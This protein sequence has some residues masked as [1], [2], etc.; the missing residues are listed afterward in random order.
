MKNKNIKALGFAALGLIMAVV[1]LVLL[2]TIHESQGIMQA[3]P[4]VLI[5]IGCGIFGHNLGGMISVKVQ[6]KYPEE[7]KRIEIEQ[8]D[9]RNMAISNKAKAKAYDIMIYVYSTI[10]LVSALMGVDWIFII[11]MV[12]SYLFI[13]L[14][15]VYFRWKY[16]KEM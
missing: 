4:F 16:E 9:E 15:G 1:G 10:M 6:K 11:I 7:A 14:T 8:K 5:G 12:V 3:F 2:K 13:V